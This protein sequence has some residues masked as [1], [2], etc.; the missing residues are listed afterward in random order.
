MPLGHVTR[1]MHTNEKACTGQ[2]PSS[3]ERI[4]CYYSYY[5]CYYAPHSHSKIVHN[6]TDSVSLVVGWLVMK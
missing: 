4:S 6:V 2:T 5:Y 1:H 3:T